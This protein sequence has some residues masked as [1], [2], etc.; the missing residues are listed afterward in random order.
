MG[1]RNPLGGQD[2]EQGEAPHRVSRGDEG[3]RGGGQHGAGAIFPLKNM[4]VYIQG[5]FYLKKEIV[6]SKAKW[7]DFE[8][9]RAP[10]ALKLPL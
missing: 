6:L 1:R 7:G 2:L 3:R 10:R 8:A 9:T 4:Y 5:S